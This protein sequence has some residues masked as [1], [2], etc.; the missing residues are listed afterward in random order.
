MDIFNT[1]K[2]QMAKIYHL[3]LIIT[4]FLPGF[5]VFF[6][7]NVRMYLYKSVVSA[8]KVCFVLEK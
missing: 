2:K 5:L 3:R 8:Q 4:T 7:L 6:I 1:F